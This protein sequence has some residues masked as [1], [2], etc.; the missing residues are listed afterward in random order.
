MFGAILS[1]LWS[2]DSPEQP[3]TPDRVSGV[4]A[5]VRAEADAYLAASRAQV[6]AMSADER[7][8]LAAAGRARAGSR[9]KLERFASPEARAAHRHQEVLELAAIIQEDTENNQHA[10]AAAQAAREDQ[11]FPASTKNQAPHT[12]I[13]AATPAAEAFAEQRIPASCVPA[14][15]QQ[16]KLSAKEQADPSTAAVQP[17]GGQVP[18]H[19]AKAGQQAQRRAAEVASVDACRAPAREAVERVQ[20]YQQQRHPVAVAARAHRFYPVPAEKKNQ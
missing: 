7:R 18:E 8:L 15:A 13:A 17:C 16:V 9:G 20:R 12:P 14:C 19:A 5:A 6:A 2:Q 10:G 11:R 3:R 4:L 1:A